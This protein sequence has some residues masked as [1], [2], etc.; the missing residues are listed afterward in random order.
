AQNPA[1]NSRMDRFTKM[2]VKRAAGP[3]AAETIIRG[4]R[5]SGNAWDQASGTRNPYTE[6]VDP[7]GRVSA[8]NDM[9]PDYLERYLDAKDEMRLAFPI[10]D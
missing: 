3:E 6:Y 5:S 2:R 8:F 10:R 4:L 7:Y 1:D 9:P